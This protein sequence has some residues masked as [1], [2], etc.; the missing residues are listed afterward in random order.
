MS[1]DAISGESRAR[2]ARPLLPAAVL[3]LV[4][5]CVAVGVVVARSAY[6]VVVAQ[7]ALGT[8]SAVTGLLALRNS[9]RR[10]DRRDDTDE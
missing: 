4:L 1:T 8:L 5:A 6:L 3:V 9:R 7:V 10:G 2:H